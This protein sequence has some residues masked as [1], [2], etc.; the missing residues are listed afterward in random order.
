MKPKKNSQTPDSENLQGSHGYSP[1]RRKW[2][3]TVGML[4]FAHDLLSQSKTALAGRGKTAGTLPANSTSPIVSFAFKDA[5]R[6]IKPRLDAAN[7][8]ISV[9]ENM[10]RVSPSVYNDVG[11]INKLIEVLS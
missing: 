5:A 8:N 7:I 3:A 11:D 6:I 2:L 4:P 10:F 1:S 9:Y